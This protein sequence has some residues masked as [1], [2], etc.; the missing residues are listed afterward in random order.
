MNIAIIFDTS[1]NSGGFSQSLSSVIHLLKINKKKNNFNFK[2]ITTSKSIQ[3]NLK[4]RNIDSFFFKKNKFLILFDYLYKKIF[5]NF[6]IQKFNLKNS[7]TSY[8]I[9]KK[10]NLAIFLNP[11][12]LIL[13]LE[14][15]NFVMFSY[16]LGYK[17]CNFFPEYTKNDSY[18]I[19]DSIISKSCNRAFRIIVDTNR[20]K[21]EICKYYNC[22]EERINVQPFSPL[23]IKKD[24]NDFYKQLKINNKIINLKNYLFYPAHFWPHKNHKYIIDAVDNLNKNY[25][26]KI[27]IV[28]CG[29]DK[30]NLE[31]LKRILNKIL[32]NDQFIFLNYIN[33]KELIYLYKNCKALVI[34]TYIATSTLPLYE[35]FYYKIPVLYS[36]GVLDPDLEKFVTTFDLKNSN[37][38]TLILK[39]ICENKF[40]NTLKIKRGNEYLKKICNEENLSK[41]LKKIIDDYQFLNNIWG[42]NN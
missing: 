28:F 12:K 11:S 8:L 3:L 41:N 30:G 7:F 15:I 16:D 42:V 10:I 35:A 32:K 21:N 36:K 22:P 17:F 14:N 20:S 6:L 2:I 40:K 29:N 31:Y 27:K 37:D 39:K 24:Y 25:N 38:L 13:Q 19:R 4:K 34:P 18:K 9:K 5:F 23:I 1:E 33:D 26:L